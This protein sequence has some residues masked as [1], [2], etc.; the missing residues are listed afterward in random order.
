M[1]KIEVLGTGCPKCR[2]MLANLQQAVKD[3]GVEVEIIKVDR[4]QEIVRRGIMVTPAL[5]INGEM[6]IAGKVPNPDQIERWI[7]SCSSS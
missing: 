5:V 1:I 4:V 6:V 2:Q 3:L 7:L